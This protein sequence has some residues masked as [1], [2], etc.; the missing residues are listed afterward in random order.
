MIIMI[1]ITIC[2]VPIALRNVERLKQLLLIVGM[3]NVDV[4]LEWA[5]LR[6]DETLVLLR[7]L[8]LALPLRIIDIAHDSIVIL[9]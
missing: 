4:V 7:D 6:V 2:F 5:W 1:L 3:P 9:I 8:C